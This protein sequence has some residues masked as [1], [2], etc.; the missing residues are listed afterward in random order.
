MV[1]KRRASQTTEERMLVKRRLPST[2]LAASW[3]SKMPDRLPADFPSF[4]SGSFSP[5]YAV[6]QAELIVHVR[7]D[8]EWEYLMKNLRKTGAP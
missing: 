5:E 4:L 8:R 2:A 7:A 3:P 6:S 1:A